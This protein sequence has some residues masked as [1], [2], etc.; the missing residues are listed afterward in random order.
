MLLEHGNGGDGF[1]SAAAVKHH[2]RQKIAD[3][4]AQLHDR[5]EDALKDDQGRSDD[6]RRWLLALSYIVGGNT[7]WS[8][9]VSSDSI[10]QNPAHPKK[11]KRYNIPGK[12]VPRKVIHLEDIGDFFEP[13]PIHD[14]ASSYSIVE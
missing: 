12:P 8:Q 3:I 6:Y 9:Q 4:D 5:L 10:Q 1:A 2:V 7:W 13:E 14:V 11:T